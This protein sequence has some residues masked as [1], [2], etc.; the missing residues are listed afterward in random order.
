MQLV[1][2]FMMMSLVLFF[3][4]SVFAVDAQS[5]EKTYAEEAKIVPSAT[6]GL[7]FFTKKHG[8]EWSCASCHSTPPNKETRH[9]VTDKVIAPLA[10]SANPKRFTDLA[11]VD[12]WFKRNCKDVLSRECTSAEK[13]DVLA[14]LN[15]IR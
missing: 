8:Q 12:K 15:S 9:I 10:P 6:R 4:P 1:K 11:K 13:A 3:N 7:E 2:K 5:L 14:Y